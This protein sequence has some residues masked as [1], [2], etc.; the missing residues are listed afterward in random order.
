MFNTDMITNFSLASA[1]TIPVIVA[2]VQALKLTQMRWTQ[3][4]YAPLLSIV[5]GICVSMMLVNDFRNNIG[6]IALSGILFGL[7]A[8]GLYSGL[9]T[10][11]KAITAQ[12]NKELIKEDRYK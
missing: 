11:A 4:K 5:V 12:R 8:S 1:A 6:E 9:R 2:I 3:D 10:T 7:S